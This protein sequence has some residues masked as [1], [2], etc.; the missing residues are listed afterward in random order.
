MKSGRTE[1]VDGAG[2]DGLVCAA[3]QGY[4]QMEVSVLAQVRPLGQFH[5]QEAS[6]GLRGG[7]GALLRGLW[8]QASGPQI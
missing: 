8:S 7:C 1:R 6:P 2:E 4:K 5:P 3:L